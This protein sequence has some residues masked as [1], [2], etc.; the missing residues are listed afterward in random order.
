MVVKVIRNF[1]VKV[2]PIDTTPPR[3]FLSNQISPYHPQPPLSL[4]FSL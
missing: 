4:N 1:K 3:Q 2:V